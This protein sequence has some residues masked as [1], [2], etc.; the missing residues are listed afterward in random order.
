MSYSMQDKVAL[1]TGGNSGIG[2]ATA[3]KLADEDVKVAIAGRNLERGHAAVRA[4]NMA[5]GE[6][7][8]VQTDVSQAA[9]VEAL[10]DKVLETWGRLDYAFNNAAASP[11][12]MGMGPIV[13]VTEEQWD[14]TLDV[15]LKGVWLAMKYEIPA[16][17]QNGGGVIV[18]TSSTA[19]GK[20]MAG[21]GPYVASKH[22]LNGLTKAA[23]LEFAEAG[24]RINA[25]MPGPVATPM[26]EQAAAIIP[27]AEEQFVSRTPV[28]RVAQPEEIA[29]A[30]VWLFSDA[31]S[32]VTGATMPVDGGMLEL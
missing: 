23:A 11:S 24:I 20:G 30:V 4:I 19:G 18:N 22:G 3:H 16:M 1:I 15:N 32:Y 27:G 6:A 26:M 14:H 12:Q 31:A 25:V 2:L 29:E 7:I 10:V 21:L 5:G 13:N 9:A 8:F 17:L 28:K